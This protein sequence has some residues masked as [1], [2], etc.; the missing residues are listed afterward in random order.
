[1]RVSR[2]S[3]G[4]GLAAVVERIIVVVV[5][6]VHG[7]C[8]RV[9]SVVQVVAVGYLRRKHLDTDVVV[10]VLM[11]LSDVVLGDRRLTRT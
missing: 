8:C 9:W 7:G 3:T 6:D 11:K 4:E 5:P 10:R 2:I 1:M